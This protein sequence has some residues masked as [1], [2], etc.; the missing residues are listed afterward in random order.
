MITTVDGLRF[1]QLVLSIVGRDQHSYFL[2]VG[3][4]S[5]HFIEVAD[6]SKHRIAKPKK[7]NL[8]HVKVKML[9]AREIEE[10]ILNGGSV[11]DSQVNAAV[12][13]LKNELEEG[14]RFDG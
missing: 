14:D 12:N 9:V 6:G 7:K 4:M 11:V 10:K 1:G 2:I 13:R 3:F 5:D 8:K